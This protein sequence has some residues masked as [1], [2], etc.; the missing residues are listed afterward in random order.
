M[1]NDSRQFRSYLTN[2]YRI[3]KS[4]WAALAVALLITLSFVYGAG[5]ATITV[6][7]PNQGIADDGLCS[8]QEA[9][10]SANFDFGVAPSAFIPLTY[11]DTGCEPGIGN[12]VIQLDGSQTY[13]M[14]SILVEG[15]KRRVLTKM[16][17]LPKNK[18]LVRPAF[19]FVLHIGGRGNMLKKT[20]LSF[21]N[22]K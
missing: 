19:Y 12:D 15:K 20:I 6:T 16:A 18:P 22:S 11:F 7:T 21:G 13:Q 10:Y 8:L 4:R 9:I 14:T 3:Q 2:G 17:E 5:A 1:G